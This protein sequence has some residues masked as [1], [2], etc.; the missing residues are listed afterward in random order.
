MKSIQGP[1]LLLR[2]ILVACLLISCAGD[3]KAAAPPKPGT[4]AYD[5]YIAGEAYKAGE[6]HRAMDHLAR[7]A[8][9]NS[10]YRE[11]AKQWLMVVSGGLADGFAELANAYETGARANAAVASDYRKNMR[12]VRNAANGAA[13]R[14]AETVRDIIGKNKDPKF[15]FEFG[16]PAGDI[17]DS[18]ELTKITNGLPL[19]PAEHA[20]VRAKM[21]ARGVVKY[22]AAVAGSPDDVTKAQ[23]QF[24][25]PPREAVLTSTA[26]TLVR[27]ADLYSPKKLDYPQRG[28]ALC[29]EALEAISI[30]PEGPDR[31]KLE[32]KAK[33]ELKRYKVASS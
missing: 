6:Y 20:A 28:N 16:F 25:A 9:T 17:K 19:Q 5:W 32:A 33:D 26:T 29:T 7:L 8:V 2:A 21:A 1:S 14:Y 27:L 4:L 18:V 12:E 13:M 3:K 11:R 22:A 31:K 23:S 24:T 30:L 15:Q 10:E